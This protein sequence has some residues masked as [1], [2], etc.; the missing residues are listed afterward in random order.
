MIICVLAVY[1]SLYH[2]GDFG[3]IVKGN[4]VYEGRADSQ[5]KVRGHRVDLSEIQ[6]AVQAVPGL[7]KALVLCYKPGRPEQV[8]F[9]TICAPAKYLVYNIFPAQTSI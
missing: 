7:D 6:K 5:I 2:T 8:S 4:L 9:S 3:R 1:S